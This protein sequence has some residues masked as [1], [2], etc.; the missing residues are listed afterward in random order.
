[1][2]S[3]TFVLRAISA[4]NDSCSKAWS[5]LINKNQ[6]F[7]EAI[8]AFKLIAYNTYKHWIASKSSSL[9]W[10]INSKLSNF[11]LSNPNFKSI[12]MHHFHSDLLAPLR[13]SSHIT[14]SY[15]VLIKITFHIFIKICTWLMK[16][17][18]AYFLWSVFL[19]VSIII[20]I[21]IF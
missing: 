5:C 2:R 16:I 15:N 4:V 14:S 10:A 9:W 17:I 7:T 12:Q 6:C 18:S 13:Y 11:I 21:R 8:F 20:S 1:M 19:V 3:Q